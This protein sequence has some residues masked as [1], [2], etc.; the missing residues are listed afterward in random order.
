[1]AFRST[2]I[3][4]VQKDGKIAM[5]GDAQ[6]SAQNTVMKGNAQ[7]V[8]RIYDGKILTGFAGATADAFTL[9]D[10]FEAKL[11][12]YSGNLMRSAVELAKEWRMDKM[13]RRLEAMMIVADKDTMLLVTGNGDVIEPD[14]GVL[15]IG[16]GGNYALSAGKALM[17]HSKL[18]AKDIA[19]ESL[20][21]AAQI[22]V[23]TNDNITVETF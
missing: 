21:I 15:A 12:A 2:T 23:Y 8:R 9:L 18:A 10:L 17:K 7:K 3:C 16:S 6:V 13:L 19:K 5:A 11:Q 14:E 20:E 22:C 4:C 1:M